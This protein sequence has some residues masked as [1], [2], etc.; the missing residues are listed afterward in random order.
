MK[1]TIYLHIFSTLSYLCQKEWNSET[2]LK[3]Q[4]KKCGKWFHKLPECS[5]R[6]IIGR[7]Y[8]MSAFIYGKYNLHSRKEWLES[9]HWEA[10][11]KTHRH[12]GG[13]FIL[14][15]IREMTSA[16]GVFICSETHRRQAQSCPGIQ[17]NLI[18]F[19]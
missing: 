6:S 15:E 4:K 14:Q 17:S 11:E 2:A 16:E 13:L 9:D 12:R 3:I 18:V 1:M 5:Y 19:Y 10:N 7:H 8:K